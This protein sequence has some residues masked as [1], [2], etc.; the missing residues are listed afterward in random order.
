MSSKVIRTFFGDKN[1]PVQWDSE[2]E[3]KLHYWW[4]DA[5]FP[6]PLT[7]LFYSSFLPVYIHCG[8]YGI[9]RLALTSAE[10]F[11]IKVV[12]GY[13]YMAIVLRSMPE[14]QMKELGLLNNTLLQVYLKKMPER[15]VKQYEPEIRKNLDYLDSYDLENATLPELLILFDDA[16]E[17]LRRHWEIHWIL[18]LTQ[19]IGFLIFEQVYDEFIG[20]R[21]EK[22]TMKLLA[23]A[24]N[25]S[26]EVMKGL[27]E[28]AQRVKKSESLSKCLEKDIAEQVISDLKQSKE[29]QEFLIDLNGYLKEYGNKATYSFEYIHPS[30]RE[31]PATVLETIKSYIEANYDYPS[32]VE[33]IEKGRDEAVRTA[34][35]NVKKEEDRPRFKD[36]LETA[37]KL[38]PLTPNHHFYIDQWTFT[39][40]RRIALEVAKRLRDAGTLSNIDDVFFLT[41]EDL[42][43]AASSPKSY[44]FKGLT[45]E[46]RNMREVQFKLTPPQNL[47]TI[48]EETAKEVVKVKLWGWTLP[49]EKT[50]SKTMVKGVA[51]SQGVVE[52]TARVVLSIDEFGKI[53]PKDILVCE[54]TNP[55]WT[56]VFSKISAVV[57]NTGGILAH[58]GIVAREFHI[59]AVVGT[60]HA[61][62]VIKSGQRI[63]VDGNK[64]T[65]EVLSG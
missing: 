15:W 32:Q 21:D 49:E 40:V 55:V 17:I 58:P 61:T 5:H 31:D 25:K 43:K 18:N 22:E 45:S 6:H 63:R 29:G 57:T 42:R 13:M 50:P 33:K 8:T 38:A 36:S 34:L 20:M 53:K 9:E 28:L 64:G 24:E 65:V 14:K 11:S 30:W 16:L 56:P 54:M 35:E 2:E 47:G 23:S 3:K 10:R 62:K 51:A 27:W 37:Q 52:G 44:D 41:V 12:N 1:F 59:P 26:M 39:S 48:T 4:D 7:P 60:V 19:F 46:R